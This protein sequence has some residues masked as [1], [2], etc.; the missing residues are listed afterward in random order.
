M[1]RRWVKLYTSL[2]DDVKLL[3]LP[4]EDRWYFVAM[5]L[6]AG[7]SDQDGL[8]GDA[9]DVALMLRVP[10]TEV[11]RY[12]TRYGGRV[13]T[14]D[15]DRYWVRDWEDWQTKTDTTNAERQARHRAAKRAQ[16]QNGPSNGESNALRN[17]LR[18]GE[19]THIEV[20]VEK[21][22]SSRANS[23]A[24]PK[25][26]LFDVFCQVWGFDPTKPTS[27]IRGLAGEFDARCSRLEPAPGPEDVLL[28]VDSEKLRLV[29]GVPAWGTVT[30]KH[31]AADG[32][33]GWWQVHHR[34]RRNGR[35]IKASEL[36]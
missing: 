1:S 31:T 25:R 11:T 22:T 30:K 36:A 20:E 17:A 4:P 26:P 10:V 29:N 32:F 19:V 33:I 9:E 12:V 14:D 2:L 7:K 34:S 6:A 15:Q 3:R 5:I 18:N 35:P 8:I 13:V 28:W 27:G 24:R 16:A 21:E 23:A